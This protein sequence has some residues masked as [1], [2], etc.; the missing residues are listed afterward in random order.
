LTGRNRRFAGMIGQN[1]HCGPTGSPVKHDDCGRRR[2]FK[3]QDSPIVR[4]VLGCGVPARF[5][6]RPNAARSTWAGSSKS[7]APRG[8]AFV[9]PRVQCGCLPFSQR[10]SS[11]LC[12]LIVPERAQPGHTSRFVP[13]VRRELCVSVAASTQRHR[14]ADRPASRF[15]EC[16]SRRVSARFHG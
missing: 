2:H 15:S 13:M 1:D 8:G 4:V 7:R 12:E 3:E 10:L 9:G 11:V 5:Q 16:R 14:G 6:L